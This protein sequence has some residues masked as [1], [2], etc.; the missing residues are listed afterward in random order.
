MKYA[1]DY[2]D[3]IYAFTVGSEGLYR[4]QQKEGKGYKAD[5]LVKCIKSFKTTLSNAGISKKVG[6]ADSWNKYQD[7]TADPIIPEVEILYVF[8]TLT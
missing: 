7:G 6:T 2:K 4:E 1:G 8:I 3:T 5:Y